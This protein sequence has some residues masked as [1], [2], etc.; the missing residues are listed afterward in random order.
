MLSQESSNIHIKFPFILANVPDRP[1]NYL[2]MNEYNRERLEL[3]SQLPIQCIGDA[4]I[5]HLCLKGTEIQSEV[6][7]EVFGEKFMRLR[8]MFS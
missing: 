5:M 4:Q 7:R 1:D 2:S 3:T 8:T 6:L